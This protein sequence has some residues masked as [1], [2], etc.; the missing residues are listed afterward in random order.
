MFLIFVCNLPITSSLFFI[1]K[2]ELMQQLKGSLNH[3]KQSLKN[4]F[5]HQQMCMDF[6]KIIMLAYKRAYIKILL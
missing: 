4:H 5:N 2:L 6:I 1:P 3:D